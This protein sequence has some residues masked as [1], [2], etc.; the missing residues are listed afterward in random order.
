ML[1]LIVGPYSGHGIIFQSFVFTFGFGLTSISLSSIKRPHDVQEEVTQE[2][3][4]SAI[5]GSSSA[6]CVK[7]ARLPIFQ[8][9]DVKAG[10]QKAAREIVVWSS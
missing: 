1:D 2:S 6:P 4:A 8:K 9:E 10:M 5:G 7:R 3:V